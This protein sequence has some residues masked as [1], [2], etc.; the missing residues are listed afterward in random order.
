MPS[1][2][3]R[4]D[5]KLTPRAPDTP[6]APGPV[7]IMTL[8]KQFHGALDA[9][10]VGEMLALRFEGTGAAVYV[11]LEQATGTLHGRRGSFALA[12]RGTMTPA[13]QS[14]TIVIA[15]GSGTGELAGISGT[16]SIRIEGKAHLYDMEYEVPA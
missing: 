5:V 15:P 10:S 3:G 11:A 2:S 7:G 1:V 8:D 14:L 6:G 13:G 12:H 9:H 4:F 16:M